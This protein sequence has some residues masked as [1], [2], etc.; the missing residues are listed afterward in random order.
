[1]GLGR[2]TR[3]GS[4]RH[5]PGPCGHRSCGH[6]TGTSGNG[7]SGQVALRWTTGR[8][9]RGARRAG[10]WRHVDGPAGGRR[11]ADSDPLDQA[12]GL[13]Q[14]R[15]ELRAVIFDP[16]VQGVNVLLGPLS[17]D[18]ER[19]QLSS[20]VTQGVLVGPPGPLL[21][22]GQTGLGLLLGRR[23][24][25][26][27]LLS[28]FLDGEV[29]GALGQ[30]QGLA[31]GLLAGR[32]ITGGSGRGRWAYGRRRRLGPLGPVHRM[33]EPILHAFETDGDLLEELVD[34]LGVIAAQLLAELDLAKRLGRDVH[35]SM[36]VAP[37]TAG[38][39]RPIRT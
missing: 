15:T 26:S 4:G 35:R 27:C 12:K 36:L 24:D 28:C 11:G 13:G 37:H 2:R 39:G 34:V 10:H 18:L 9:R 29:G 1:M 20:N 30:H 31:Q 16:T 6:G 17:C 7:T 19:R 25:A 32:R 33:A 21:G 3:S 22:V 38:R 5:R 8:W 23:K 14:G